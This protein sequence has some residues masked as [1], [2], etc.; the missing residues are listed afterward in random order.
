MAVLHGIKDLLR[1]GQVNNERELPNKRL[2]L[3]SNPQLGFRNENRQLMRLQHIVYAQGV[4]PL[5]WDH[6]LEAA[7]PIS[8]R[9]V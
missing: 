5:T 7:H 9:G 2:S 1:T 4:V 8:W 3:V 6:G